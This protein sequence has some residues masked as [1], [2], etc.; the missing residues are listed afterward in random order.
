MY[1]G[2][3]T[4]PWLG[5]LFYDVHMFLHGTKLTYKYILH[6]CMDPSDAMDRISALYDKGLDLKPWPDKEDERVT[7][8]AALPR[9]LRVRLRT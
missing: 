8:N 6:T 3:C 9:L 5:S 2:C 4:S 1:G 7:A